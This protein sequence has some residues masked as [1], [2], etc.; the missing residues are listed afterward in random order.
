MPETESGWANGLVGSIK[1]L[2]EK[3]FEPRTLKLLLLAAVAV[4]LAL[5]DPG[6][7]VHVSIHIGHVPIGDAITWIFVIIG[8]L[9]TIS[10]ISSGLYELRPARR[11]LSTLQSNLVAVPSVTPY[12]V[13]GA[14]VVIGLDVGRHHLSYGAVQFKVPAASGRPTSLK[15]VRLNEIVTTRNRLVRVGESRRQLYDHMVYAVIDAIDAIQKLSAQIQVSG[16]SITTPSWTDIG[17]KTLASPIGP[18]PVNEPIAENLARY[19]WQR[20][21][22]KMRRAFESLET[23]IDSQ[24]DLM[25][26][27]FLDTD[28]RSAVRYDL[29][30][31]LQTG[32]SWENYACV[33]ILEGIGAGLILG[34]EVYYGSHASEG[35]IGHTTVHLES[36]YRLPSAPGAKINIERCACQLPGIHWESIGGTS[37]LLLLA[38]AID[39]EKYRRLSETFGHTAS[40]HDLVDAACLARQ[41]NC[42]SAVTEEARRLLMEEGAQYTK[43]LE[44]VFTEYARLV[45]IGVA[46]IA[47]VLDLEHVVIGGPLIKDLDRL[48][49]R[50]DVRSF[51]NDYVLRGQTVGH[52]YK[53]LKQIWQGSTLLF[54]DTAYYRQCAAGAALDRT[55][56]LS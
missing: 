16:L 51:W 44:S 24:Q 35:E 12:L 11:G 56:K 8:A 32:H 42:G 48:N 49:F 14:E 41:A 22:E 40:G 53:S 23:P 13:I 46:N 43:Y 47:N 36:E 50:N 9:L 18:F 34:G 5:L 7:A 4:T 54:W 29:H 26:R 3:L 10:A 52:S 33:I 20:H 17:A 55:D 37:G 1:D 6:R 31:R 27:I 28:S 45:T 39:K 21:P 30:Q 38:E 15:N 25:A 2:L 19:L